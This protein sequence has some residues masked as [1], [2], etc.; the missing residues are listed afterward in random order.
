MFGL[1]GM[2]VFSSFVVGVCVCVCVCGLCLRVA[3]FYI[4]GC[5]FVLFW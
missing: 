1:R 3:V 2:A 4:I 5:L